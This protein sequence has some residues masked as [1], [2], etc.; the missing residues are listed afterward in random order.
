MALVVKILGF[1]CVRC[2]ELEREVRAVVQDQGIA[3]HIERVEDL[4]EMLRYRPLALPGLVVNERLVCAGRVPSK[5]E[6]VQLL[7]ADDNQKMER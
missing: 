1:G 2:R 7:K 6:L 4:M 5:A 3:A